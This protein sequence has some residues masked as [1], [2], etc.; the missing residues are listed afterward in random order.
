MAAAPGFAVVFVFADLLD[1]AS[2]VAWILVVRV[3][4]AFAGGL[5]D[6]LIQGVL[7]VVT[8]GLAGSLTALSPYPSSFGCFFPG[9]SG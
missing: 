3:E 1:L 9:F 2:G 4:P 5:F 7:P 8:Y 6:H